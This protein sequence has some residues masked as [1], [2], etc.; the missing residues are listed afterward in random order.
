MLRAAPAG[1]FGGDDGPPAAAAPGG[2]P[3]PAGP[4]AH[5][6]VLASLEARRGGRPLRSR[7]RPRPAASEPAPAAVASGRATVISV[8]DPFADES[9]ADAWLSDAGEAELEAA[10]DVLDRLLHAHRIAT[11]DPRLAPLH[12]SRLIAARLG[13]GAGEE[14]ADGRWTAARELPGAA[15]TPGARRRRALPHSEARLAALLAGAE[16]PL[17]CEELVLRGRLDLECGRPREAALQLLVALDAAIAELDA[18]PGPGLA[19]RVAT[20]RARR[21]STA[22]AA[23]AAL[24]GPLPEAACADVAHTLAL[25]ESALRARLLE[26]G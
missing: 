2:G 6:V 13:Y 21:A 11:A 15:A 9:A 12:R 26:R 10:L 3:G 16:A 19:E 18:S 25:L 7:G 17:A 20:L 24:G 23:Q 14:V 8:R 4:I 5:V 22:A 1:A